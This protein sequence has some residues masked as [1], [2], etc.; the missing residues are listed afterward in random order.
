MQILFIEDDAIIASG[1]VYA[2]EAEGSSVA[3]CTNAA[4]AIKAL[5]GAKIHARAA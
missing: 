2:L 1:L 5:A 3:H 4:S